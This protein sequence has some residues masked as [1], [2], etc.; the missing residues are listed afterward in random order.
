MQSKFYE[1]FAALIVRQWRLPIDIAQEMLMT[2]NDNPDFLKKVTQL[3]TNHECIIIPME[4]S[5]TTKTE[6]CK[7]SWVKYRGFAT[8]FLRS[9]FAQKPHNWWRITDLLQWHWNHS[10]II[11]MKAF[12]SANNEKGTP[13]SVKCEGFLRL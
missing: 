4:A 2:F 8:S 12:R 10:P 7:Q 13:S 1:C 3:M 5:R 11:P 9:R 6:K